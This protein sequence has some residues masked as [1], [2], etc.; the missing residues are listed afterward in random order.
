[1]PCAV[2]VAEDVIPIFEYEAFTD[3]KVIG[4]N[5]GCGTT[6]PA[7]EMDGGVRCRTACPCTENR[8]VQTEHRAVWPGTVLRHDEVATFRGVSRRREKV[9]DTGLEGGCVSH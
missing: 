6:G 7:G 3:L 4:N 9:A 1:M 5:I 2:L 8:D